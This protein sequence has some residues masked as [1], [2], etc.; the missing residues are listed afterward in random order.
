MVW[1]KV[2]LIGAFFLASLGIG[3]PV[4][5]ANEL[6]IGVVDFQQ[7]LN[8]VNEGKAAKSKL[9]AD[10]KKK[11][12]QLEI[13]QKELEELRNK[14]QAEAAVLSEDKVREKQAEFQEKFLALRNK[15][16]EY[17]Q[18]MVVQ[19]KELSGTIL[20]KL[21]EIVAEVGKAEGYTLIVEKSGDPVLY[22]ESKDDLT[23]RVVGLYNK[24]Y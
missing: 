16:L 22:V 23:S 11:Q 5:A 2:V 3:R 10:F 24:K 6:K 14:L 20:N 4:V 12:K 13:Q 19:E 17:Q 21:K 1:L 9:E 18:E 7:A 8:E 15:T